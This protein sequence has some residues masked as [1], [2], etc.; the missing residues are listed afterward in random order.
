[1]KAITADQIAR[2]RLA[3]NEFC[4]RE[5]G[6]KDPY[7]YLAPR[8]DVAYTVA[9]DGITE[10]Q[11]TV[12]PYCCMITVSVDDDLTDEIEFTDAEELILF[13]KG[14]TFDDM[15]YLGDDANELRD[16]REKKA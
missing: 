2:L 3:I 5:Y 12:L 4:Q 13:I 14:A 10:I 8:M 16:R 7:T 15:I 9:S 11:T 1:M 6:E